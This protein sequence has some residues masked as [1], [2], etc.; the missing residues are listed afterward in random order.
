MANTCLTAHGHPARIDHRSHAERGIALEPQYKIGPNVA[1][2]AARGEPS[3]RMDEHRTIARR[4][5]EWSSGRAI[6]KQSR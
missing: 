4:N 3:E 1:R 6:E 2:R 5:A